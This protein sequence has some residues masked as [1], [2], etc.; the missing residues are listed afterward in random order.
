MDTSLFARGRF[1]NALVGIAKVAAYA[2]AVYLSLQ[3]FVFE[4]L[5]S[6]SARYWSEYDGRGLNEPW[7]AASGLAS[8]L[9]V[10]L[11]TWVF[12]R[13]VDKGSW[14]RMRV[15]GTRR[16]LLFS[17]GSLVSLA[18]VS[19]IVL[20]AVGTGGVRLSLAEGAI[21]RRVFYL[22]LM[23]VVGAALVMEEEVIY[24]GYMLQAI[25]HHA[26]ALVA[27]LV[28][29]VLFAASHLA[30]PHASVLGILNILL[31]GAVLGAVCLRFASLW[32]AIGLHFGWNTALYLFDFPV[33]GGTYPETLLH[34][35][36]ARHGFLTGSAFGPEDSGVVTVAMT[37]LLI[38]V[39]SW[40]NGRPR[41][42]ENSV[43]PP[44]GRLGD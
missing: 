8:L 42:P 36:W 22:A 28:T 25:E 34:M 23:L 43:G 24:R 4:G 19:A 27:V 2:I 17:I 5:G 37:L 26:G 40:R 7:F 21:H 41:S 30:R 9:V 6:V 16:L 38:T 39:A 3:L 32:P 44:A 14:A 20:V 18:L 13:Y 1:R 15:R 11:V 31:M 33:S 10:L 29:S 12:L 35:D